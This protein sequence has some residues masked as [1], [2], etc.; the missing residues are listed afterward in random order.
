MWE[1][2]KLRKVRRWERDRKIE[3]RRSGKGEKVGRRDSEC[4]K[5]V[6]CMGIGR[7]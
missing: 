2:G 6:R 7:I 4:V 1:G 5:M 3:R